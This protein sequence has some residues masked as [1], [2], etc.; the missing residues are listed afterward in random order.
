MIGK[1][2]VLY[3][4]HADE[5]CGVYQFGKNVGKALATSSCYD[6]SYLECSDASA[7]NEKIRAEKPSCIIYNYHPTTA[8]WMRRNAFFVNTLQIAMIHEVYQKVADNATD[9]VFDYHIG[10]DPT[11]L[12]KNPLVFKTGRVVPSYVNSFPTPSVPTIGSFGFGSPGKGFERIVSLVQEEF[13]E[14]AIKLNIPFATF[15]DDLGIRAKKIAADCRALITKPGIKL[16]VSHDF[17]EEKKLLDFL[18]QNTVNVFLYEQN[19]ARGISSVIEYAL[20]VDRPIA[21][22]DSSMFRHIHSAHPSVIIPHSSLKQIIANGTAPLQKFKADFTQENLVWEYERIIGKALQTGRKRGT[23][24]KLF[25]NFLSK[26]IFKNRKQA[27]FSWAAHDQG[28]DTLGDVLPT[29]S[30][31]DVPKEKTKGYNIIL[32]NEAREIYKPII[33]QMWQLVPSILQKKIPEANVQQAFVLDSAIKLARKFPSPKILAVGSYE[34]SAVAVLKKLGYDVTETDPVLNYDLHT[35]MTKP[36]AK[37]QKF[38]IVVST[39]VIEHVPNDVEFCQDIA[40]VLNPNGIAI[41][42]CDYNDQYK[43]GDTIPAVDCRW[44]TQKDIKER[45]MSSIPNCSLYDGPIWDCPHPD[46]VLVNKYTYTFASLVFQR[47]N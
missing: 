9:F 46:F 44:Y 45:L 16:E 42:T 7:L 40:Q 30:F 2:K 38:D 12:L 24:N 32:D 1:Q 11:L 36:S 28:G 31:A 29:F 43:P 23:L 13:E 5:K 22:S 17:L 25:H 15:G 19:P 34:D 6:I 8:Q 33:E 21:V 18:A 35:Y 26:T 3:V 39:S 47:T 4:N 37:G 10:A 20:A 41:I 27:Y 14:A